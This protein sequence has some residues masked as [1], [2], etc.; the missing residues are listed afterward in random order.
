MREKLLKAAK[1]PQIEDWEDTLCHV[2]EH[3]V[4]CSQR[5]LDPAACFIVEISCSVQFCRGRPIRRTNT[6]VFGS[7][8]SFW[9]V[10]SFR[11]CFAGLQTTWPSMC[12]CIFFTVSENGFK[13]HCSNTCLLV[14]RDMKE[15]GMSII[16]LRHLA[17][18]PSSRRRSDFSSHDEANA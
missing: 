10:T 2:C 1:A 5:S 18:N 16:C 3:L 6:D 15:Q 14:M 9:N 13:W 7:K 17:W 4:A 8:L 12:S 11:T